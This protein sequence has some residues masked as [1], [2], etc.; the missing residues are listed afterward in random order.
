MNG[1]KQFFGAV[2]V[3]A[4]ALLAVALEPI[5]SYVERNFV[6]YAVVE[7]KS[8]VI[9]NRDAV[10][11]VISSRTLSGS[12][13]QHARGVCAI[14]NGDSIASKFRF[15]QLPSN[16][17]VTSVKVS[18][19]DIG[20]TTAMDIGVYRTTIDGGA[21]VDADLFA[22]ALSLNGGAISKSEVLYESG[23]ITV[24]NGEKQL[25][26]LAG[27]SADPKCLLDVV[28]TLTGAADAAGSVL[29]EADYVV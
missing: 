9:S 22:S 16:A 7:G 6:F 10:P 23:V 11:S 2:K 17:L 15:L 1:M 20:T 27:L 29:V 5:R 24:A 14:T 28:G 13:L 8:T 4:L 3:W 19:P 18:A 21:V 12:A 26:Q 25:W